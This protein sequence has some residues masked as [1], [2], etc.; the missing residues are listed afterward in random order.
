MARFARIYPF[1]LGLGPRH[2]CHGSSLR[3]FVYD[4]PQLTRGTLHC[5]HGQWGLEALIP[6]WLRQG[7]CVTQDAEAA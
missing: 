1:L 5:H 6:H 4:L 2:D 3:L 7:S